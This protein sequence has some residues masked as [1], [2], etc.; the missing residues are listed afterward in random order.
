MPAPAR[1]MLAFFFLCYLLRIFVDT[2]ILD[3]PSYLEAY[4]LLSYLFIFTLIPGFA[5]TRGLDDLSFERFVRL[6]LLLSVPLVILT[7]AFSDQYLELAVRSFGGRLGAVSVNPIVLGNAGGVLVLTGVFCLLHYRRVPLVKTFPL[8]TKP[9]AGALTLFGA[10]ILVASASRGPIL[11]A[12][13]AL[14]LLLS[15]PFTW[16]RLLKTTCLTV[17]GIF[18]LTSLAEWSGSIYG[19]SISDRF[20]G[21]LDGD[22]S[23]I[24]RLAAFEGSIEQF[25]SSPLWGDALMTNSIASYPHNVILEAMQTTGLIGGMC[26]T[27]VFVTAFKSAIS[28][29]GHTNGDRLLGALLVHASISSMLSGAIWGSGALIYL[30]TLVLTQDNRRDY[31]IAKTFLR[32]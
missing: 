14:I 20:S 9:I 3:A 1:N 26:F 11:A 7:K 22:E 28:L 8:A 29:M 23:G 12:A 16:I 18:V 27:Y 24:I 31:S 21:V 19:T 17:A 6:L 25:L 5:G 13:I 10:I 32:K 30:M 4:E 15:I 2:W